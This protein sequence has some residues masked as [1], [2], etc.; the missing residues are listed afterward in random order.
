[1]EFKFSS[2]M[3]NEVK[4]VV[5]YSFFL[6]PVAIIIYLCS[7]YSLNPA[8][9]LIALLCVFLVVVSPFKGY[10]AFLVTIIL[11][12]DI[13]LLGP[14][15]SSFSSLFFTKLGPLT[16][17][18]TLLIMV[19]TVA[20]MH[21]V[22]HNSRKFYQFSSFDRTILYFYLLLT[23]SFL[24]LFTNL[25]SGFLQITE[26]L[27]PL[28]YFL[29]FY[30]ATRLIVNDDEKQRVAMRIFLAAIM[31][32]VALCF[33]LTV[34]GV[35]VQW[36]E[37]LIRVTFESGIRYFPMVV[38][39]PLIILFSKRYRLAPHY[40]LF[41]LLA[42]FVGMYT[43]FS[44][45]TRLLILTTLA[46]LF[47]LPSEAMNRKGKLAFVVVGLLGVVALFVVSPDVAKSMGDR[48]LQVF[49][50]PISAKTGEF[51]ALSQVVRIIEGI[52]VFYKL[53]EDKTILLGAGP[54]S[55]FDDR[56]FNFPFSSIIGKWDYDEKTLSSGRIFRPHFPWVTI[57][58][59]AGILGIVAHFM[60]IIATFRKLKKNAASG[61]TV[62]IPYYYALFGTLVSIVVSMHTNKIYGI[63]GLIV[64]FIAHDRVQNSRIETA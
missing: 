60:L 11:N 52:N 39:W 22:L 57:F 14:D 35:G 12:D 31:A 36:S 13:P 58:F 33:A 27:Y 3:E 50:S 6:L 37:D 30:A 59:K 23:P 41:L 34:F 56:Y 4:D 9:Q 32:K 62:L 42:S 24:M 47:L 43:I 19:A 61:S 7:L 17:S 8:V 38:F 10:C 2:G 54:G 44:L 28:V 26:D 21:Y 16:C 48:V 64:A 46:G 20:F 5:R 55:W 40:T 53:I 25:D 49:E 15:S 1:M 63:F 51:R 29:L 45:V 18:T